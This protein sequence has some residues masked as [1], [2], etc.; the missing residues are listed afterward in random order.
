MS[1]SK[2]RPPTNGPLDKQALTSRPLGMPWPDVAAAPAKS[3][4]LLGAHRAICDKRRRPDG[5]ARVK[6]IARSSGLRVARLRSF[7]PAIAALRGSSAILAEAAAA[8]IASLSARTLLYG[9]ITHI[10]RSSGS[11]S[12]HHVN[13]LALLLFRLGPAGGRGATCRW[14]RSRAACWRCV[15]TDAA[16]APPQLGPAES[17]PP[18]AGRQRAREACA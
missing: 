11:H 16:T 4:V 13:R 3:Q 7:R 12:L 17:R 15:T 9:R 5:P 1:H 2:R 10:A 6:G 8:A 14:R 18:D